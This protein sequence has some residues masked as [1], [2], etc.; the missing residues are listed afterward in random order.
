[1]KVL[2]FPA[3]VTIDGEKEFSR[4]TTGYGYMVM[5]IAA[6][7]AHQGVDVDL[8]TQS[9]ITSG[10]KYKNVNIL[11]RTYSD[12][13]CNIRIKHI[14]AAIAIIVK[15]KIELKRIPYVLFYYISMGYF[16]K[17]LRFKK[18]DLVHV[19]GIGYYTRPIIDV[20]KKNKIKFLVTLHG[21]N[22]FSESIKITKKER[23]NEK[24]FLR[25]AE[26][27]NIPVTVISTGIREKILEFLGIEDSNNFAVIINGHKRFPKTGYNIINIRKK[28]NI[29][30]NTKIMI[31]VG[32]IGE[33][34]NQIQL[35]RAY[36]KLSKLNKTRLKIL[37]LG[38]DKSNG[39]FLDYINKVGL[40]DCL[41]YCGNIQRGEIHNYYDQADYN[42]VVSI[43]EGFGL[44]IIEGF[45]CGLPCLVFSDLDAVADLYDKNAMSLIK[46]RSD[47]ELADGLLRMVNLKF[48][49]KTIIDY[50]RRFSLE[51]VASEYVEF[52][53]SVN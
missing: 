50:S 22:A 18:Y 4:S 34:K 6:A 13:L 23:A 44:S 38:V 11:K 7:V 31:C 5:D 21:L 37:F 43:S 41:I 42:A 39:K 49:K 27:E 29:K 46:N 52:Y 24:K 14:L 32:N 2:Q 3:Y 36:T 8:I 17:I 16:E 28:Y 30:E 9:N 35:A 19:H 40:D 20:C 45:S 48:N 25:E 53:Q 1:M 51:K 10:Y 15:D 47:D 26:S 33:N 12:I